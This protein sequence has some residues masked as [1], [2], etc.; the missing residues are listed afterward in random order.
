[1]FV[2]SVQPVHTEPPN[3]SEDTTRADLLDILEH[4][5]WVGRD[6]TCQARLFSYA[7]RAPQ[8]MRAAI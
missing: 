2:T 5:R 4:L 7:S 3:L 8:G 1:M 6:H